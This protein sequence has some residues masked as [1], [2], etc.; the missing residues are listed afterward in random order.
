MSKT[1][2]ERVVS[3]QFDNKNFESN[4][5][6]TMSTLEKLKSRLN[7]FGASK[8]LEGINTAAKNCNL[9]PIGNAV[10]AV[11]VKFSGLQVA[12]LTCLQNITNQAF[13]TG[14]R[15]LSSLTIEPVTTGFNE[16]ELKMNSI[17][18]IMASTGENLATVNG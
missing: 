13:N 6:T 17:Q 10:D 1:I 9:S 15:I 18:T 2:D 4:V 12:A 7:L 3:M 5:K 8:G 16:Y 14:K 11:S